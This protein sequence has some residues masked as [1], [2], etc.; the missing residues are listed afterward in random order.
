MV[1]DTMVS[2]L[3]AQPRTGEELNRWSGLQPVPAL[4]GAPGED[5]GCWLLVV[6]QA[7][8][9]MGSLEGDGEKQMVAGAASRLRGA[10]LQWHPR[11]IMVAGVPGQWMQCVN[12]IKCLHAQA[13]S[14]LSSSAARQAPP[15]MEV[16]RQKRMKGLVNAWGDSSATTLKDLGGCTKTTVSLET[17]DDRPVFQSSSSHAA[18]QSRSARTGTGTRRRR[19]KCRGCWKR[20]SSDH[21]GHHGLHQSSL[22]QSGTGQGV[23]QST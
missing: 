6:E 8:G 18:R 9:T 10:A 4:S 16:K 19:R 3:S 14:T 1:L 2:R 20:G 13:L 7:L 11:Q 21:Q 5:P 15:D 12:G 23:L 17:T 22:W